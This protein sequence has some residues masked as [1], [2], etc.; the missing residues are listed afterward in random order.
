MPMNLPFQPDTGIHTSNL[1]SESFVGL[2]SPATRQ[3]AGRLSKGGPGKSM[4][5]AVVNV[6]AGWDFAK[7]IVVWGSAS[8]ARLSQVAAHADRTAK[9][10]VAGKAI[11]DAS[12]ACKG[13]AKRVVDAQ[14]LMA[15]PP[16]RGVYQTS[17]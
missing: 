8:V 16:N 10:S 14:T 13:I 2:I 5:F 7:T 17:Q 9:A 3:N 12:K 15:V 4:G 11:M 6:P 1:M